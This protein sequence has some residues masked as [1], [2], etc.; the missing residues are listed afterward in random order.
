[1]HRHPLPVPKSHPEPAIQK[2]PAFARNSLLAKILQITHLEPKIWTDRPQS[3]KCKSLKIPILRNPYKKIERCMNGGTPTPTDFGDQADPSL[4][5]LQSYN[6][7]KDVLADFHGLRIDR[8][9][10]ASLLVG[11]HRNRSHSLLLVVGHVPQPVV[12]ARTPKQPFDSAPNAS[13][14]DDSMT[15]CY[16]TYNSDVPIC[17]YNS[18]TLRCTIRK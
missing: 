8:R 18:A 7:E 14:G 5:R 1:M 10:S 12:L 16:C 3:M 11:H 2:A 6:A 13:R 9:L 17:I 4:L 15:I